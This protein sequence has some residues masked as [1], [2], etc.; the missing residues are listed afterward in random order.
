[1]YKYL[2]KFIQEAKIKKMNNVCYYL[3]LARLHV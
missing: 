3:I 1:M 2:K